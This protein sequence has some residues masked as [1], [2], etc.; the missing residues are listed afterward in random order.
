MK[1]PKFKNAALV[2]VSCFFALTSC[3]QQALPTAPTTVI[4]Q[5]ALPTALA[6][7]ERLQQ[8]AQTLGRFGIT[9]NPSQATRV[10]QGSVTFYTVPTNKADVTVTILAEGNLVLS[11]SSVQKGETITVTDLDTSAVTVAHPKVDGTVKVVRFGYASLDRSLTTIVAQSPVTEETK[12]ALSAQAAALKQCSGSVPASLLQAR[13]QANNDVASYNS[14]IGA[15]IAWQTAASAAMYLACGTAPLTAGT[16]AAACAVAIG[17]LGQAIMNVED[18]TRLRN[19]AQ[20]RVQYSQEAINQW[21]SDYAS[22]NNC[23]WY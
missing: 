17:A 22:N 2:V 4:E 1:H 9:M 23:V 10:Q 19:D 13:E 12:T 11:I 7:G 20:I 14:Q 21:K 16:T 8:A 3:G 6:E 5:A 15:A 18:K